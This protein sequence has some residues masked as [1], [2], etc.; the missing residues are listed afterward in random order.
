MTEPR[1]GQPS[2]SQDSHD[3][4]KEGSVHSI[5]SFSGILNRFDALERL[6]IAL[7]PVHTVLQ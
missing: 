3:D 7:T 6:P 4:S 5:S 2:V 1:I